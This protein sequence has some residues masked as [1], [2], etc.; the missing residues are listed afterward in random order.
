MITRNNVNPLTLAT[1]KYFC[2]NYALSAT[3]KYVCH[4]SMAIINVLAFSVQGSTLDV[5][6]LY[7]RQILTS[8]VVAKINSLASEGLISINIMALI[9]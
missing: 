8:I 2:K 3:L 7:R 1:S 4:G 5:W 9:F 6:T